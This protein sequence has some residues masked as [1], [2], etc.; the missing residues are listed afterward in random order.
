MVHSDN[1]ISCS[2]KKEG[3]CSLHTHVAWEPGYNLR[4]NTKYRQMYMLYEFFV[5]KKGLNV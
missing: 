4:E 3:R 5:E 2:Y 1:V